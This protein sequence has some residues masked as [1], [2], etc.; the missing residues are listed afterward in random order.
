M[1]RWVGSTLRMLLR[2]GNLCFKAF[3]A[4]QTDHGAATGAVLF[5]AASNHVPLVVTAAISEEDNASIRLAVLDVDEVTA[6]ESCSPPNDAINFKEE[7]PESQHIG[8][9]PATYPK[10]QPWAQARGGDNGCAD[11][12]VSALV[13]ASISPSRSR[14]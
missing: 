13:L 11:G 5:R 14:L 3:R 10:C 12:H 1:T 9:H 7:H 4:G 2:G 6:Y 8:D